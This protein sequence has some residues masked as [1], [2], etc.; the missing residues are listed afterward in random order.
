MKY[1]FGMIMMVTGMFLFTCL[2]MEIFAAVEPTGLSGNIM[3]YMPI[4]F[5][6]SLVLLSRLNAG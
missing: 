3:T 4:L 1:L 2:V 6:S 5:F